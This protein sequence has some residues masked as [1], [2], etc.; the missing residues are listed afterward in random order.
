MLPSP[1]TSTWCWNAERL[2]PRLCMST[3]VKVIVQDGMRFS[4]WT[5]LDKITSHQNHICHWGSDQRQHQISNRLSQRYECQNIA[6]RWS[7]KHK[8]HRRLYAIFIG[9]HS[10][11]ISHTYSHCAF[12]SPIDP[13]RLWLLSQRDF[14]TCS[15]RPVWKVGYNLAWYDLW[16]E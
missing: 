9:N 15:R 13:W 8:L 3:A 16:R 7:C 10:H 5:A 14:G 4:S 1:D 12:V 6:A 2:A 11:L